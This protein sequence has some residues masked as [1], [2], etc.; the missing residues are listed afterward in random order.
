MD[1]AWQGEKNKIQFSFSNLFSDLWVSF[2]KWMLTNG[3]KYQSFVAY[4][5][6]ILMLDGIYIIKDNYPNSFIFFHVV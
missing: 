2:Q 4:I 1:E 5:S 3:V 6:G